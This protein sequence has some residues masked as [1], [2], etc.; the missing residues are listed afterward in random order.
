MLAACQLA[1]GMLLETNRT[2]R[3]RHG[4]IHPARVF[5]PSRRFAVCTNYARSNLLE[6]GVIIA[7]VATSR[8]I[9]SGVRGI[10]R[11]EFAG[12]PIVVGEVSSLVLY[13]VRSHN[14]L[15]HQHRVA[16]PVR[17]VTKLHLGGL[18]PILVIDI[19]KWGGANWQWAAVLD[20]LSWVPS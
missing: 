15:G 16:Q 11:H 1:S 12:R 9:D 7:T 10:N 19:P 20:G 6:G 18:Y 5:A 8:D 17:D 3:V 14:D 2:D 4:D 13:E